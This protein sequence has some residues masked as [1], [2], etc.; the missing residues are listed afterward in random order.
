M[1][2]IQLVP[3]CL[4]LV[5]DTECEIVYARVCGMFLRKPAHSPMSD[6]G[7]FLGAPMSVT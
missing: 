6:T 5:V 2:H 4:M 1:L 3:L 7:R